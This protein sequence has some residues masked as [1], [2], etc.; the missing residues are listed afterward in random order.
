MTRV[1]CA[2][3][4]GGVKAAAHLGALRALTEH[5]FTP[6]HYVGTSM[7]ALIAAALAAGVTYEEA[8]LALAGLRTRDVAAPAA[9]IVLG[10]Y[11]ESLFRPGPLR[12]MIGHLVPA[13][14]FAELRVPLTVVTVDLETGEPVLFGA[15]GRK[16]V[17]LEDAL[18]A[19]CALP[20]YFPPLALDGRLL[21]DGGLRSV[22]PLDEAAEFRP[23]LLFAVDVGP[24]WRE[25]PPDRPA[26]VPPLV[27]RS[28][29]VQR[30]LMAAQTEAAIARWTARGAAG[31]ELVLVQP[32]VRAETTF[33]LDLVVPYVEEGY[34]AAAAALARRLAARQVP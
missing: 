23:D 18:Y 33:R 25:A 7:G 5:G 20:L 19:S 11:G 31:P 2:L 6:A 9:G 32:A 14:T 27:R 24:S 1:V 29:Q 13:R 4:G 8:V 10:L 26:R 12:R 28:G 3:S 16:D 17:P 22:L 34:R 15:G 21:V 30:V